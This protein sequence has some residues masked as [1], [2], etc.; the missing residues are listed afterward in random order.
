MDHATIKSPLNY[1]LYATGIHYLP[2]EQLRFSKLVMFAGVL[3]SL[4]SLPCL[5]Y[6]K[7]YVHTQEIL[8]ML[9]VAVN[10]NTPCTLQ[11]CLENRWISYYSI[12]M[13]SWNLTD[14]AVKLHGL[15]ACTYHLPHKGMTERHHLLDSSIVTA[16]TQ[17][18]PL[19]TAVHVFAVRPIHGNTQTRSCQ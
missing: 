7:Q 8:V 18:S 3:S 19:F 15:P 12:E 14:L 17:A 5:F 1:F 9:K 13:L 2:A 6:T 16:T 10:V 4:H 11:L